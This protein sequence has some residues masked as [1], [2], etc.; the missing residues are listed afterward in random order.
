MKSNKHVQDRRFER[1]LR[2][3]GASA[4]KAKADQVT[5]RRD[6]NAFPVKLVRKTAQFY[7]GGD[8]SSS[9]DISSDEGAGRTYEKKGKGSKSSAGVVGRA[10]AKQTKAQQ[11]REKRLRLMRQVPDY[12]RQMDMRKS[13]GGRK[14]GGKKAKVV[15][16]GGGGAGGKSSGKSSGSDSGG[17]RRKTTKGR[18]NNI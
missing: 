6:S 8:G 4:R 3:K 15:P 11:A 9:S 16:G 2:K 13:K 1:D 5:K 7:A 17:R 12:L 14:K 18:C 10:K